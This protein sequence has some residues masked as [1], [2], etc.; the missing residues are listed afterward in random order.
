MDPDEY[1]VVVDKGEV[2]FSLRDAVV[3]HGIMEEEVVVD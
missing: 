2:L 3:G 1:Q